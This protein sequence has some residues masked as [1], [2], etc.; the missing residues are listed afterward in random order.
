MIVVLP[1]LGLGGETPGAVSV[2][3]GLEKL[4][5]GPGMRSCNEMLPCVTLEI[6]NAK[7]ELDYNSSKNVHEKRLFGTLVWPSVTLRPPD[8]RGHLPQLMLDL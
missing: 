1:H 5:C 7:A 2:C 6:G 8:L 4:A 3:G